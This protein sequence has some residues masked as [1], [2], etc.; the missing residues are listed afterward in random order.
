MAVLAIIV[1][2]KMGGFKIALNVL[3]YHREPCI[4][5]EEKVTKNLFLNQVPYSRIL[6]FVDL[7][8]ATPN[9]KEE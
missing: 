2:R 3:C 9:S 1:F 8:T 5:A 6:L 4:F 7:K